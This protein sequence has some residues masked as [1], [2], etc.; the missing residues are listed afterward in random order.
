MLLLALDTL[1][2]PEFLEESRG[3][4]A[5][6]GKFPYLPRVG[7]LYCQ[8]VDIVDRQKPGR[9]AL[10]DFTEMSSEMRVFG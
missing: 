10:A 1:G 5:Q 6:F 7:D 8:F 3:S 4:F 2:F 9:L